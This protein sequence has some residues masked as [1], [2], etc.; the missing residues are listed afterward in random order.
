MAKKYYNRT[1]HHNSSKTRFKKPLCWCQHTLQS[2]MGCNWK[3]LLWFCFQ[4]TTLKQQRRKITFQNLSWVRSYLNLFIESEYHFLIQFTKINTTYK[5]KHED[6]R[7]NHY[8]SFS[9]SLFYNFRLTLLSVM[10]IIML[11]IHDKI[12]L[13]LLTNPDFTRCLFIFVFPK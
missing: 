12:N 5:D 2:H 9:Y 4:E 13:K 1:I 10:I 3:F 7:I 8:I 6:N 11:T